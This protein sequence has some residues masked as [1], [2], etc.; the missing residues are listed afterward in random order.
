MQAVC[1]ELGSR[2]LFPGIGGKLQQKPVQ[3][4]R[5]GFLIRLKCQLLQKA[6]P[7]AALPDRRLQLPII[8]AK[9]SQL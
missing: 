6:G 9:L 2:R 7:G 5:D 4:T 8:P 3:I 1:G